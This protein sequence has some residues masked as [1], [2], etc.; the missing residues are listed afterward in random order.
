MPFMRLQVVAWK[1]SQEMNSMSKSLAS[2]I[3]RMINL[4]KIE[5]SF[6]GK[7]FF[8]DKINGG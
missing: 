6:D 5:E 3:I 7:I 4:D 2:L 8:K 1:G